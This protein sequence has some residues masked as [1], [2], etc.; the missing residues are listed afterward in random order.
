M[1]KLEIILATVLIVN[2]IHLGVN[3]AKLE[4]A[5]EE[6][7]KLHELVNNSREALE[8]Y[9]DDYMEEWEEKKWEND[10]IN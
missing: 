5:L 8:E 7:K 2:L 6:L 3:K 10:C 1:T 4:Q 9:M